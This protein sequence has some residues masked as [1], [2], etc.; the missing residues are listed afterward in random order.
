MRIRRSKSR[1]AESG[2]TLIEVMIATGL[3]AIGL[4]SIAVAQLS[5]LKM[6][7]R[8]KNLSRAMYLAEVQLD[9]FQAMPLSHATFSTATPR[10]SASRARAW[11]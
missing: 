2:F 1:Q 8:S 10:R 7:A 5:A 9:E 11:H 3:I 4:L 6:A